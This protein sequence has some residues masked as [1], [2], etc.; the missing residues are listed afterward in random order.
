MI[1]TK[2]LRFIIG[3]L[4]GLLPWI[5]AGLLWEFPASISATYYEPQTITPFMITLGAAGVLLI[6]YTGYDLQDDIINTLAGVCGLLVCLFPCANNLLAKVGTF[7]VPQAVSGTVHNVAAVLFFGLLAYNSLFLFTKHGVCMT[8]EKK[9]RNVVY[10]ICGIGMVASF[11]VLLLPPFRIKVWLVETL[12]L[13]FFAVS[14]LTKACSIKW[15][16][17]DKKEVQRNG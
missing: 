14:W 8:A 10:I 6:A 9:K 12:A 15:L 5:V 1:N 13:T 2:R 11:A 16:F 4:G 3:F 17:A 7:Q